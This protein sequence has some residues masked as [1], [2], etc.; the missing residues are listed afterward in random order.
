MPGRADGAVCNLPPFL[1]SATLALAA[2]AVVDASRR[3]W[4]LWHLLAGA[5]ASIATLL[6]S[7]TDT[8]MII[9]S[10]IECV[11]VNIKKRRFFRVVS[12]TDV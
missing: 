12:K 2:G 6:I 9:L 7:E 11:K 8:N 4:R 10:D 5:V 3:P 1:P